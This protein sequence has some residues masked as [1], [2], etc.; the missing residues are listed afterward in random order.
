M[1]CLLLWFVLGHALTGLH[2]ITPGTV[3]KLVD[4]D[5]IPVY[6]SAVVER[7]ELVFTQTLEPELEVRLLILP[8]DASDDETAAA[9]TEAPYG[10]IGPSGDDIFVQF[11]GY[12]RAVSFRKWLLEHGIRLIFAPSGE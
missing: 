7:N 2:E 10:R 9:A 5:L 12:E 6:A 4:P 3:V 11:E 8:P 1:T